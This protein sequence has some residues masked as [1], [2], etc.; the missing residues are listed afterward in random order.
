MDNK[1]QRFVFGEKDEL[2]TPDSARKVPNGIIGFQEFPSKRI[3]FRRRERNKPE[4]KPEWLLNS[5][6]GPFHGRFDKEFQTIF[7]HAKRDRRVR[8]R[9]NSSLS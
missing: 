1:R 3:M 8:E 7:C 9:K 4:R 2:T 6:N 5:S